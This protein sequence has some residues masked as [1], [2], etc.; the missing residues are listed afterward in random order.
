[1]YHYHEI[2][3]KI[4]IETFNIVSRTISCCK[5]LQLKFLFSALSNFKDKMTIT[6]TL[7]ITG[8]FTFLHYVASLSYF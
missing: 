2:Y 8:S 3:Y 6:G 4:I 5:I 1:M 7:T